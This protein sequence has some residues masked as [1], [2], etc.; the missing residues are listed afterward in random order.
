ME[1]A[2]LFVK[3]DKYKEL[4]EVLSQVDEKIKEASKQLEQLQKLKQQEDAQIAA[5]EASLEDVKARS[6]ELHASLFK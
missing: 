2:P 1:E 3:I 5:W 4:T 6:G